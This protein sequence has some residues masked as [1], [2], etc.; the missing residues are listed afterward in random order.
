MSVHHD[1][2]THY[3]GWAFYRD[4]PWTFP[5][6]G[7][8]SYNYPLGTNIGFT[9]SIPLLALIFKPFRAIL[10]DDFQY[11]GIWLFICHFLT[12]VY[13]FKIFNLYKI[14]KWLT[15]FATIL[16]AA[17]P[18]LLFRC[19]H[20]ALSAHFLILAS[21]YYYLKP[22]SNQNS[23]LIN[24]KQIIL[25]F[26]AG[27]IN[28]YISVMIFSFNLIIPIKHYLIEKTINLKQCI[29]YPLFSLVLFGL[30]W[31]L[32]GIIDFKEGTNVAS[33][34]PFSLYSFNLNSFFDSYGYYSKLIPNLGKVD[35]R[36]Y[37]GFA[38]LG[39]GIILL[40]IISLIYSVILFTKK[41]ITLLAIKKWGLL[42][43]L[44]L[45]L[46]MFALTNVISLNNQIIATFPLPKIIEKLGFI[47]R[48]SGRFI[49]PL[50]YLIF[51]G[52]IFVFNKIKINSYLKNFIFLFIAV[53]QLWDTQ[54]LF[55]RWKLPE[56]VYKTPL[57][58]KNWIK[59]MKNFE[60]I[61]VYPSFDYNYNINYTNDYQ[62][63]SY[64]A[65]KAK[66]PISNGY[67]AR[68]N[69]N[70]GQEFT[71]NLLIELKSGKINSKRLY[72][73]T[74]KHFNAFDVLL[75]KEIVDIHLMD[76]FIFIYKKNIKLKSSDFKE[77]YSTKIFLD[78]VR[79]HYKNQKL[80]ELTPIDYS[81]KTNKPIKYFFDTFNFKENIIK[82]RGW[83]ILEE[84]NNNQN[85]T[86]FLLLQKNNLKFEIKLNT[87][88]RPDIT[89]YFKKE[90]LNNA[91][92]NSVIFTKNLNKGLYSV[93]LVI[94]KTDSE[95]IYIDSGRKIIIN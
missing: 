59:V 27:T 74:K 11:F 75:N 25:F 58:D 9:D 56:G 40:L 93:G 90:N 31:V 20:P 55:L 43:I 80:V 73:T 94:K 7:T 17:N 44:C 2:G 86:I 1:W 34:E 21:M 48:A 69:I 68:A 87:E 51:I 12:A 18:V 35:P 10:S 54:E 88:D 46:F 89:T 67:V 3:L 32:I 36:Q 23:N 14:N 81:L 29:F 19:I 92:F 39:L 62:D 66:K 52:S 83:A 50:Y 82:I 6:G 16:I 22:S 5:L 28:P 24:F 85:E 76:N 38:Y 4:D 41:R 8:S 77:N 33:S 42:L 45:I 61:I 15:L 57:Q 78:S 47:F 63:L 26:I 79:I 91:G 60:N 70:K 53:L 95:C 71:A 30:S 65:L 37:E 84:S 64:L 72:I 13:T 49:W